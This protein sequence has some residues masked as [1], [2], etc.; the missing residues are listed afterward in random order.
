MSD[1]NLEIKFQKLFESCQNIE[2]FENLLLL[3]DECS[4]KQKYSSR[5]ARLP[6]VE[7]V[8]VW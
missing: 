7:P 1:Q 3:V 4:E 2:F 8:S 5:S 6:F